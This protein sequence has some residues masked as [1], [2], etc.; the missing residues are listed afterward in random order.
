MK[1]EE[2]TATGRL[3]NGKKITLTFYRSEDGTWLPAGDGDSVQM[4]ECDR[5]VLKD[6]TV[7]KDRWS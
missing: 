1:R 4:R 7:L 2:Q 5:V 3:S 6:G